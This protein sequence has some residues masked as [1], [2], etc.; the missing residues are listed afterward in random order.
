MSSASAAASDGT[1]SGTGPSTAAAA[2]A[3]P[4]V[5]GTADVTAGAAAG[6]AGPL[7][8][9][10][11]LFLDESLDHLIGLAISGEIPAGLLVGAVREVKAEQ[12]GVAQAVVAKP[13]LGEGLALVSVRDWP[14][15]K[16]EEL[17]GARHLI[18]NPGPWV[19]S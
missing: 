16:G 2:G 5:E 10:A 9:A 4:K 18:V 6:A 13:G 1:D 17:D 11:P 14:E 8:P 15:E 7:Q 12:G 19:S 3:Q